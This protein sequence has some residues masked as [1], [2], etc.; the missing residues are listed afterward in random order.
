MAHMKNRCTDDYGNEIGWWMSLD[1]DPEWQQKLS[2]DSMDDIGPLD[3][4]NSSEED[5][6]RPD[7]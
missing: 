2:S 4:V 3:E 6:T 1:S 5:S 7:Q